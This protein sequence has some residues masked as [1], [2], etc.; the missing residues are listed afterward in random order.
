MSP[1]RFSTSPCLAAGG[2]STLCWT[3]WSSTLTMQSRD[4]MEDRSDPHR[5]TSTQAP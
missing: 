2:S 5:F 4:L 1:V 3:A